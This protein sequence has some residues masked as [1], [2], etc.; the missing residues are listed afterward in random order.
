MLAGLKIFFTTTLQAVWESG[1][2]QKD[3]GK[4]EYPNL[5]NGRQPYRLGDPFG[6]LRRSLSKR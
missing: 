5:F 2:I 3:G 1:T 4:R 6:T